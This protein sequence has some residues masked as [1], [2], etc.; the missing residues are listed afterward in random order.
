MFLFEAAVGLNH[1]IAVSHREVLM[2]LDDSMLSVSSP[3]ST[4]TL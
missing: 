4:A 2:S 1:K 3:N